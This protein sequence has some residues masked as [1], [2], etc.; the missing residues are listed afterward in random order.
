MLVIYGNID[1]DLIHLHS[2]IDQCMHIETL[3]G[4]RKKSFLRKHLLSV[5]E[6]DFKI[7]LPPLAHMMVVV[8]RVKLLTWIYALLPH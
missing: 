4:K 7:V 5:I 1:P 6:R 3:K 2:Y 8:I